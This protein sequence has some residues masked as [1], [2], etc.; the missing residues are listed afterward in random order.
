MRVEMSDYISREA[1]KAFFTP[2]KG[3]AFLTPIPVTVESLLATIDNIPAADV[4]P[5][6]LCRDCKYWKRSELTPSYHV[7]TYVIGAKFVRN[8]DDFCS[9]GERCGANMRVPDIDVGNKK[10]PPKEVE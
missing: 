2:Q 7:C 5:V 4:R 8:A 9:R 3:V 1:A 10:E 6:V